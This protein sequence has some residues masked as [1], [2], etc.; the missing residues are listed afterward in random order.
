MVGVKMG[1]DIHC[2]IEKRDKKIDKWVEL[3]LYKLQNGEIEKVPVYDGRDYGLFGI[4]AG[5][6][7]TSGS[8]VAVRGMPDDLSLT[9]KEEYGDGKYFHSQTWYDFCELDAY[10]YSLTKCV[11]IIKELSNNNADYDRDTESDYIRIC[12][13]DY[14]IGIK[15]NIKQIESLHEFVDGVRRVLNAYMVTNPLPGDVRIIMWFDS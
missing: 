5:V 9:V 2:A 6:R 1:C 15:Y 14:Y 11:N 7:S 10:D 8:L 4:L 3:A 12:G 13:C